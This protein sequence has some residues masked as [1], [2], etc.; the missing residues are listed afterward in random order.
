MSALLQILSQFLDSIQ[1]HWELVDESGRILGTSVEGEHGKFTCY[2]HA[3]DTRQ[4]LVFYSLCPTNCPPERLSAMAELMARMNFGMIL[5]NFELDMRD[6]EI[7][8]KTAIDVE[9]LDFSVDACKQ[10]VFPNC[11]MMDRY[12][13]AIEHVV[14]GVSPEGA[15]AV[16]SLDD[17]EMLN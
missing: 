17:D 16:L 12:L 10:L 5:G 1:W 8:Y 14:N 9:D 2:G 11:M 3:H 7:R 6:G 13:P 4:Q 15:L